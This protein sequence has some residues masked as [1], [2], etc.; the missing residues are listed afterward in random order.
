M[1]TFV[2]REANTPI[3][4]IDPCEPLDSTAELPLG[5]SVP[6]SAAIGGQPEWPPPELLPDAYVAK[7]LKTPWEL[8]HILPTAASLSTLTS[9]A[10]DARR[11]ISIARSQRSICCAR[12]SA[13]STMF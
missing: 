7:R 13:S 3:L 11:D 1:S 6:G 5:C 9:T 10:G 8:S 2:N 4:L 12:R